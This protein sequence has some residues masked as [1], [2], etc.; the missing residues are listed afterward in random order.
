M[1]FNFYDY[2]N[3]TASKTG[4]YQM[5]Y[6]DY[7]ASPNPTMGTFAYKSTTALSSIQF[8]VSSGGFATGTYTLVG[9][10]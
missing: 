10:K 5:Y 7:N 9:I 8:S 3:T 2:T 4:D 1:T 6:D